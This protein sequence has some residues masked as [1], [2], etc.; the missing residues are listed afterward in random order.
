PHPLRTAA[1]APPTMAGPGRVPDHQEDPMRVEMLRLMVNAKYGTQPEGAIVDMDPA[2]AERRIAAGDCRPLDPP[3][4]KTGRPAKAAAK[5]TTPPDEPEVPVEEMTVE[6]LKAYAGEQ[7]IDLGGAT[8]KDEIR[9]VVAA[10][11][12]RRRD[13]DDGE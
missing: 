12:E 11:L 9:A 3:K 4:K 13:A 2:D 8:R 10:E 1:R 5:E 6:Q 7:E